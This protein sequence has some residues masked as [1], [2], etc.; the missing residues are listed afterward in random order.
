VLG[1]WPWKAA[2]CSEMYDGCSCSTPYPSAPYPESS[3][4]APAPA[5]ASTSAGW[6]GS[7]D[8]GSVGTPVH[9]SD[10]KLGRCVRA[11]ETAYHPGS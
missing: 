9:G 4:G 6:A 1:S 7:S 10:T 11:V 5:L 2:G 8:F 3:P